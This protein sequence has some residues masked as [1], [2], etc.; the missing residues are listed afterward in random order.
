MNIQECYKQG[1]LK[2]ISP[3]NAK[4]RESLVLSAHYIE[5]AEGNLKMDYP[6]V[7]LI[8]GY[9]AMLHAARAL[10]F[11][12]G[13]KERSHIC[14]ILYL[15]EEYVK[16]ALLPEKCIQVLDFSRMARHKTQY[17]G[18]VDVPYEE[19]AETI[20]DAKELL[21]IVTDMIEC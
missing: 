9:N 8:C 16:R 21:A 14:I 13:I 18:H 10:L 2:K 5:R 19:A 12:D 15:K 11:K 6:D 17:G 3:D 4:A 1:M 7:S 20:E